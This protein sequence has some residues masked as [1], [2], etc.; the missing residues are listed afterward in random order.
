MVLHMRS[1]IKMMG[2]R[3]SFLS[4]MEDDELDTGL[5]VRMGRYSD[6]A[7]CLNTSEK[8]GIKKD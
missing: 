4:A 5:L 2:I 7:A 1:M 6:R 3:V 8:K